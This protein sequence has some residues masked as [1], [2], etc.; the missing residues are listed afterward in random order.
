M[1]LVTLPVWS[2]QLPPKAFAE[3]KSQEFHKRETAQSELLEWGRQRPETA[4]DEFLLQSRVADDPEVRQRCLSILRDLVGDEYLKGGEGYMGIMMR[5]VTENIPGDPKPRSVIHVMQVLGDSAAQRAGLQ[6]NDVIAGLDDLVWHEGPASL[7]FGDNIRSKKP[8]SRVVLKV[9]RD[10]RL[11]DLPVVLGRRPPI[12][13]NFL[14]NDQSF[15]PE[16][17]E[18]AAKEAYFRSWLSKRRLP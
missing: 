13:N 9:L 3:L 11:M 5:D 14:F 16:A 18:R 4:L 17:I 12:P 10:G 1:A 8:N 2:V 15:D 7:P 6:V